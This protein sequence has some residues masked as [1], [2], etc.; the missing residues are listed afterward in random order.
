[1]RDCGRISLTLGIPLVVRDGGVAFFENG[2]EIHL[3]G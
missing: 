1:M 3:R 2:I